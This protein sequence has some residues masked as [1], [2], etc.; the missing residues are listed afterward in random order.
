MQELWV[1]PQT[2]EVDFVDIKHP[3][4]LFGQSTLLE[5]L[6]SFFSFERQPLEVS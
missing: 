6:N 3:V 1:Q 4:D 5:V 2:K